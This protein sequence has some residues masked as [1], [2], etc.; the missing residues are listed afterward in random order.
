VPRRSKAG[1]LCL[2]FVPTTRKAFQS[3]NSTLRWWKVI[4]S[5]FTVRSL[6]STLF[7][8]SRTIGM[9]PQTPVRPRCQLGGHIFVG[10]PRGDMKHNNGTL[11][12]A[13]ITIPQASILLLSSCVS[14]VE[15]NGP[16]V[17]VERER[18]FYTLEVR[19]FP[20][21]APPSDHL[22]RFSP[23]PPFLTRISVN[24]GVS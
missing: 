11:P 23:T 14:H 18:N 12:L 19:R 8:Q 6:L 13:V 7:P 9:F 16:T 10:K 5:A 4:C 21:R 3:Y 15:F 20:A 1:Y 2:A 17:G 24:S 22:R